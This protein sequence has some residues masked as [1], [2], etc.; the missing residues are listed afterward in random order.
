MNKSPKKFANKMEQDLRGFYALVDP[1]IHGRKMLPGTGVSILGGNE[2]RKNACGYLWMDYLPES[3]N[4]IL[5]ILP[6]S[7]LPDR[8]R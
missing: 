2:K 4:H 6:V 5:D 1:F 8:K 7:L 3:G